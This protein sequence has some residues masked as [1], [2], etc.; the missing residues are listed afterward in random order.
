MTRI[1]QIKAM[2]VDQLAKE[3]NR[4]GIFTDEICRSMGD[5]QYMD[6]DGEIAIDC[7]CIPCI[8]KWLESE[9]EEE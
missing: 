3:I 4:S 9:V 7:N 5:C 8:I 2:S 1:E 6:E